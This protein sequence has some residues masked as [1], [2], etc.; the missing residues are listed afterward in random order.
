M[1][2]ARLAVGPPLS[3]RRR[4]PNLDTANRSWVIT[5]TTDLSTIALDV[6][7]HVTVQHDLMPNGS[8]TG[9]IIRQAADV[10]AGEIEYV[11]RG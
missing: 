7:D 9:E 3:C 2:I 11:V 4:T 10:N 1:L 8:L 6:G 5:M